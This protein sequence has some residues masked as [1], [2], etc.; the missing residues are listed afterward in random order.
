MFDGMT[1]TSFVYKGR[2]PDT[3]IDLEVGDDQA[4]VKYTVGFSPANGHVW[5]VATSFIRKPNLE[6]WEFP[7]HQEG[8]T[9]LNEFDPAPRQPVSESITIFVNS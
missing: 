3:D 9:H 8:E 7:W 4:Y 2:E 6:P 1:T 5:A